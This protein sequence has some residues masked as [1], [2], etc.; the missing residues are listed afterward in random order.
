[1]NR[2]KQSG[3]VGAVCGAARPRSA[4]VP[5]AIVRHTVADLVRAQYPAWSSDSYICHDDLARFRGQYMQTLLEDEKGELTALEQEVVQS[6]QQHDIVSANIDTMF[7]QKLSFGE[8]LL[9]PADQF[10]RQVSELID[11]L[12]ATPRQPGVEEIRIPS[13][14]AFRERERRRI[15]GI[16]MERKVVQALQ[17]L[18]AS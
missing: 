12:K 10:K 8:R 14:R 5:A 4:L 7:D 11:R 17:A 16:V 13:E 9:I 1:M 18:A 3:L 6:L 15:E 2:N